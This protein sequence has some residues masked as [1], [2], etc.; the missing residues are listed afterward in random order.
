[1][2]NQDP[3]MYTVRECIGVTDP[4]T[5]RVQQRNTQ[6]Y[7]YK[8]IL[9][10]QSCNRDTHSMSIVYS[11]LVSVSKKCNNFF[12]RNDFFPLLC[13]VF[14]GSTA[15]ESNQDSDSD[16]SHIDV[17]RIWRARFH[18]LGT[19][20]RIRVRQSASARVKEKDVE[21]HYPPVFRLPGGDVHV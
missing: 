15:I 12:L 16:V 3:Y 9:N 18:K 6:V 4:G 21:R 1:M 17:L 10:V 20:W 5:D 19:S 11:N 13:F 14:S 8:T 2:H 7:S